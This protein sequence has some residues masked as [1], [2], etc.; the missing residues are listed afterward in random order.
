ML[1]YTLLSV[2]E[3]WTEGAGLISIWSRDDQLPNDDLGI[4]HFEHNT[5]QI[6]CRS[7]SHDSKLFRS[8]F[9]SHLYAL[10]DTLPKK[11]RSRQVCQREQLWCQSRCHIFDCSEC[12]LHITGGI[13]FATK[14]SIIVPVLATFRSTSAVSHAIDECW[15][16]QNGP[17]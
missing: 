6:F 11:K 15:S 16:L 7:I 17:G 8:T 10:L 3:M 9:I 1:L 5:R 13:L 12:K 4:T 2:Q 14:Q